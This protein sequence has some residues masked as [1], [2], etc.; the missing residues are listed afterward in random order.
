MSKIEFIVEKTASGFSAY[1][2]DEDL[3]IG[4]SG[5]DVSELNRNIVDAYNS[6]AEIRGLKELSIDDISIRLDVKQ[7]FDYYKIINAS[8]LGSKIGMDKTLISQYANGHKIPGPK[9]VE[10]IMKGIKQLG[11][12]LASL[13]LSIT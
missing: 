8:A 3:P 2:S 13:N 9:Q 7:F 1:A 10:K 11:Q 4:T 6:Y 5:N 12:E